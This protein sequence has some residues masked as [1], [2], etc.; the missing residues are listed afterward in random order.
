MGEWHD[1]CAPG[2]RGYEKKQQADAAEAA[3]K[4]ANAAT[5]DAKCKADGLAPGSPAYLKCRDTLE[6]QRESAEFTQRAGVATR[7]R[8]HYPGSGS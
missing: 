3:A 6:D 7:L 2:T 8:Y 1:D 5:D 4:A